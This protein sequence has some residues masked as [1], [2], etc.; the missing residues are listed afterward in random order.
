MTH[1]ANDHAVAARV[2]RREGNAASRDRVV[3]NASVA[4]APAVGATSRLADRR[5]SAFFSFPFSR[6]RADARPR[7]S[8]EASRSVPADGVQCRRR[9]RVDASGASS[10]SHPVRASNRRPAHRCTL[11]A[12]WTPARTP[13]RCGLSSRSC[14]RC[15]WSSEWCRSAASSDAVRPLHS[16]E[17]THALTDAARRLDLDV[18]AAARHERSGRDGVRVRH[19][20]AH[21]HRSRERRRMVARS[22]SR[23][24]AARARAHSPARSR[25]PHR[26]EH[27]PARSTGSIRS[28]GWRRGAFA[29][30]A[31]WRATTSSS[32]SGV[33]PSDYAQHLLDMVTSVGQRAPDGRTGDGATQGVR[34]TPRRDS[35]SRERR[36]ACSAE[37]S[38]VRW[39]AARTA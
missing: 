21:D 27:S 39:S 25:R 38:A 17:W 34:R 29:S 10:S 28:S 4:R 2:R 24:A 3:R 18:L 33:R 30:R 35:R 13:S 14:Y 31:S 23:G 36:L 7:A 8:R 15:A 1:P 11:A 37:R 26:R 9:P 32:S 20:R 19:V 12:A 22:T 5:S 16:A 6:A